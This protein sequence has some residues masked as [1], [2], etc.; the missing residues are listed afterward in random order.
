MKPDQPLQ[1]NALRARFRREGA[2]AASLGEDPIAAF[3]R[4]HTDWVATSPFDPALM[5]LATVGESGRPTIRAMDL[6]AVDHGFVF[7]SHGS[8]PKALDLQARPFGALCFAWPEIGRQVRVGGPVE[9][10]AAAEADAAFARLPRGFRL[11]ANATQ[12]SA[13]IND[14]GTIERQISATKE[15]LGGRDPTRPRSWMGFRVVPDEMEFWQQRVDDLHDRVVF[16]HNN[17]DKWMIS[18]L[19]P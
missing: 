14:R 13:I 11:V 4:W 9:L 6:V 19:S 17:I 7:M 8:S 1:A 2:D 10:I 5:T 15:E 12:Q 3:R 18:I 16:R